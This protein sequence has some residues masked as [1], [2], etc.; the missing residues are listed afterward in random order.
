MIHFAPGRACLLGEHCD[1]AGGVDAACLVVPLKV[2]IE[3]TVRRADW[4]LVVHSAYGVTRMGADMRCVAEDPNRYVAAVAR[5]LLRQGLSLPPARVVVRSTLLAGR[6]FSSSAAVCVAAAR[7]L[8]AH[9]GVE[10]D[11]AGVAYR[12]ERRDLGVNCGEMDQLASAAGAPLFIDWGPPRAE[13]RL[14]PGL[15]IPLLVAAF[16]DEI[17]AAPILAALA[18]ARPSAAFAAWGAGARRA[19]VALEA[20]D[21]V[22]LG[23]EL[24]AAQ[25]VYES[26][27]LPALQAPKL[28][29]TCDALRA[30]GALGAKFSGAGGDRSLVAVF[31]DDGGLARGRVLLEERGLI[32]LDAS[33]AQSSSTTPTSM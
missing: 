25:A 14:R 22:A 20:G 4:G 29:E 33:L 30:L 28:G 6:G 26:L 19:A 24:D 2:G 21:L 11:A 7:A 17:S 27:E 3:V 9:A 23:A 13:R 31:E 10:V 32:V 8:A 12:A 18:E 1:W 15:S 5:E 16:P